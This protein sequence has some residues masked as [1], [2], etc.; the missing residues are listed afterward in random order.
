MPAGSMGG[1]KTI[2]MT[3]PGEGT[4]GTWVYDEAGVYTY[5]VHQEN[6]K[7][8]GYKYDTTVYTITDTVKDENAKLVVTRVVTNGS[9]KQV[10]VMAFVNEYK[11]SSPSTE[12]G[13]GA[14]GPKTGDLFNPVLYKTLLFGGGGVAAFGLILLLAP[15]RR[16]KEASSEAAK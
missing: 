4:F 13:K 12:G 1:M 9:G 15:R 3:G 5:T 14:A 2:N 16:R 8:K 7:E 6:N 10:G 11:K